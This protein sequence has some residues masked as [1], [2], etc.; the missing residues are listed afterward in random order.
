MNP[1]YYRVRVDEMRLIV[2]IADHERVRTIGDALRK[3]GC[4]EG[5]PSA[6][7]CGIHVPIDDLA[8]AVGEL[9]QGEVI[10]LAAHGSER[11]DLG[12]LVAPKTEGGIIVG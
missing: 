1:E 10:Y 2:I 4:S 11:L 9:L 7:I 12:I 5:G 6:W 8:A 3:V